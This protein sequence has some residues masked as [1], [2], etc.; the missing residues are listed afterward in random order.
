MPIFSFLLTT[1]KCTIG[2]KHKM[3]LKANT[4]AIIWTKHALQRLKERKFS[5]RMATEAVRHPDRRH[6]G[7]EKGTTQFVKR[8]GSSLV[9]VV[10]K[11]NDH[12]D[13]IILSCWIDPPLPGTMDAKRKQAYFAY[14]RA[15]LGGKLLRLCLRQLGLLKF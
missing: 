15:S 1:T 8:F 2:I 5:Q 4:T 13:I 11:Q 7:T 12:K 3:L 10:A 14:K 9:T 6:S